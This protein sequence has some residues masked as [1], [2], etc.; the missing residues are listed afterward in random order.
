MKAY[1]LF[2]QLENFVF[3]FL[4]VS[5]FKIV[6]LVFLFKQLQI[7][8]YLLLLSIIQF[9]L[10]LAQSCLLGL[11][12]DFSLESFILNPFLQHCYP[13]LIVSFYRINCPFLFYLFLFLILSELFL[14][15]QQFVLLQLRSQ[16]IHLLTQPHLLSIPLI[17]QTFLLIQQLLLKFFLLYRLHFRLSLQLPL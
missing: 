10:H 6:L 15:Q 2:V 17:H 3:N 8:L 4:D 9:S 1:S 16:L 11:R 5:T 12:S 14:L 7:P 13:V